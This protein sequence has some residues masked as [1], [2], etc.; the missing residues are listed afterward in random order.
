MGLGRSLALPVP[1]TVAMRGSCRA[2]IDPKTAF[3]EYYNFICKSA[4]WCIV[5][6]ITQKHT[7]RVVT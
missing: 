1:R 5:Q 4:E 6:L 7:G 2:V 3:T